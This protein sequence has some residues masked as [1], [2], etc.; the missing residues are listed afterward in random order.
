MYLSTRKYM[1]SIDPVPVGIQAQSVVARFA[2][3]AQLGSKLTRADLYLSTEGLQEGFQEDLIIR[4]ITHIQEGLMDGVL[5]LELYLEHYLELLK[6]KQMRK[7]KEEP[8]AQR[9]IPFAWEE[10]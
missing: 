7:Q 6:Q 10:R 4:R 2:Q 5:E 8:V 9:M 1:S 3:R